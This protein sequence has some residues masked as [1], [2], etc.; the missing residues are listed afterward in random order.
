MKVQQRLAWALLVAMTIG[1]G[2][3]A[4]AFALIGAVPMLIAGALA[5]G[6]KWAEAQRR[7]IVANSVRG[8]RR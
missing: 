8:A 5:Q 6:G 3:I 4:I 2:V 7:R 1:C